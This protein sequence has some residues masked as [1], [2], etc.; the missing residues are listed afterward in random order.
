MLAA[1]THREN[2]S[3]SEPYS[4]ALK[5][6][7]TIASFFEFRFAA[8]AAEEIGGDLM[9]ITVA[10]KWRER[11]KLFLSAFRPFLSLSLFSSS[12]S[13]I[14]RCVRAVFSPCRGRQ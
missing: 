8:A 7:K 12:F 1:I 5:T 4:P 2:E 13:L 9:E 10:A 11:I 6:P 3:A 14:A